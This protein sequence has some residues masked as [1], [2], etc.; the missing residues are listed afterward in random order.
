MG[1]VMAPLEYVWRPL[2]RWIGHTLGYLRLFPDSLMLPLM[3]VGAIV[4]YVIAY[5]V[6][7]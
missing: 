3:I 4:F 6:M 1:K 2:F 5:S 7:M